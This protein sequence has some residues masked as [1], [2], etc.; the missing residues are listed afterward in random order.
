MEDFSFTPRGDIFCRGFKISGNA[1]AFRGE[2]AL[3]HGTLL[4]D[5]N[6]AQLGESLRGLEYFF[7]LNIHGPTVESN[8]APVASLVS[9]SPSV[10]NSVIHQQNPGKLRTD[11]ASALAASLGRRISIHEQVEES[12]TEHAQEIFQRNSSPDWQFRRTSFFHIS[13]NNGQKI[14]VNKGMAS[15]EEGKIWDIARPEELRSFIAYLR[16]NTEEH[17]L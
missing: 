15:S 11:F 4:I 1:L 16:R 6:L 9:L 5:A 8:P 14:S 2:K 12:Q 3:H 7:D 10:E 17:L 13:L